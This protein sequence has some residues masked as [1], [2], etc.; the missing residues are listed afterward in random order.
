MKFGMNLLL[1]SGELNDG[2]M[3]VLES[4]KQIGFDGVEVPIFD[5]DPKKYAPWAK[6]LDQLG[7][8]RTV[9]TCR[10]ADDNPIAADA[11]VRAL[12]VA[13]TCRTLD[14]CQAL[15]ATVLA[16]PY[17][18]ALGLFSGRG[19]T[20]DEW[21]WGVDGMRQVAEHAAKTGVMLSVEYLNR[22]ECYLLNTAV[23]TAR[24]VR[25]VEH[26]HCRMMYDTFHANI[27]ERNIADAIRACR[28][29]TVHVH[30]SENDRSIPGTGHVDWTTTFDTL[31]ETGYNGWLTIE[32]FGLALPEIAA[33][34]KIWRRL[35]ADELSLARE[36]LAFM[37]RQCAERGMK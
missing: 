23:D 7:L 3:P 15:G 9:V 19:P 25:E 11:K 14:C 21:R 18:S 2:L 34:T 36:G 1:W 16:G 33:A 5:F 24:F 20:P 29:E 35:F 12:G 26:P 10:G 28:N 4:L 17:H 6:R 37:R 32:A 31:K 13:N 22:F 27:E 8:A 30:I